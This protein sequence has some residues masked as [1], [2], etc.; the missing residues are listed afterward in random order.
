M[1]KFIYQPIDDDRMFNQTSPSNFVC[2]IEISDATYAIDAQGY[3][4]PNIKVRNSDY[5][6]YVY[7]ILS[8]SRSFEDVVKVYV[9]GDNVSQL[10]K[11][12]VYSIDDVDQHDYS[13]GLMWVLNSTSYSD[14]YNRSISLRYAP[15][16]CPVCGEN[17]LKNDLFD[18]IITDNV[19]Q[20]KNSSCWIHRYTAI[21]RFLTVSCGLPQFTS[22]IR[23]YI[24]LNRVC[25]PSDLYK[26]DVYDSNYS[27]E[28]PFYKMLED[29]AQ[30][31]GNIFWSQY[32]MSLPLIDYNT[33]GFRINPQAIDSDFTPSNFIKYI[34]DL[35][36]EY[37]SEVD[38]YNYPY[39]YRNWVEVYGVDISMYMS[40]EAFFEYAKYF[41][42]NNR[43]TIEANE[44][45][46]LG[47]FKKN[48]TVR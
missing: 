5:L 11:Y 12:K 30:T 8:A 29:I 37:V 10:N 42:N 34:Y 28:L 46:S 27:K 32:L 13:Y 43:N 24:D 39:G 15:L 48:G 40:I 44:L 14:R 25:K 21:N 45:V 41:Y 47:V 6:N 35:T 26:L 20:C 19:L 31:R 4:Y 23:P 33:D 1:I 9:Q 2:D 18:S 7:N 16:K 36:R 22:V 38:N 3:V 17:L